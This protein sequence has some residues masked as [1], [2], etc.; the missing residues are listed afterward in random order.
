MLLA[1][2]TRFLFLQGGGRSDPRGDPTT[3]SPWGAHTRTTRGHGLRSTAIAGTRISVL[4]WGTR[5]GDGVKTTPTPRTPTFPRCPLWYFPGHGEVTR[6]GPVR[7]K[8]HGPVPSPHPHLLVAGL[9]GGG[10]AAGTSKGYGL[11]VWSPR[12]PRY[13]PATLPT[14][15]TH[16]HH[17]LPPPGHC[18]WL[19]VRTLYPTG[20]QYGPNNTWPAW[21]TA[22]CVPTSSRLP[23]HTVDY[24]RSAVRHGATG[25]HTN[26]P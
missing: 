26:P 8:A 12:T 22:T 10:A 2:S 18:Q 11:A 5:G 25:C 17:L 3:L 24:P 1:G 9:V 19:P 14:A 15:H 13:Q 7:G 23:F 16:T 6:S 4:P 20:Y 21:D